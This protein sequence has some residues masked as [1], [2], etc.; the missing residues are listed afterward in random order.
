M[1]DEGEDLLIFY[2]PANRHREFP[3]SHTTQ[4]ASHHQH[5]PIMALSLGT[6]PPPRRIE[7]ELRRLIR[8]QGV[9]LKPLARKAHMP[10]W[11]LYR[12]WG[13]RTVVLDVNNAERLWKVL[14]GENLVK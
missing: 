6:P 12:W 5:H 7:P 11:K 13:G 14:T 9:A 2:P 1:V 10:Y 4:P 3:N 8:E